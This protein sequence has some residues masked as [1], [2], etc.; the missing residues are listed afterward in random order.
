MPLFNPITAAIA[1]RKGALVR[2]T[3]KPEPPPPVIPLP[4]APPMAKPV[5]DQIDSFT[6]QRLMRV[7]A[8][9]ERIDALLA[10]EDEPKQLKEL[11][12]ALTRLADQERILAG[13]PLPGSRRPEKDKPARTFTPGAWL[14]LS[15]PPAAAQVVPPA[16]P[17]CPSC[18]SD[19]PTGSVL[20]DNPMPS[21][22]QDG[23]P[24]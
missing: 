12:D 16:P 3:P 23:A 24:A 13:R 9:I 10:D 18:A 22:P 20:P 11:A 15:A 4:I 21:M 14:D 2:W 1:G 8:Q 17:P 19:T 6:F 5:T 7:R